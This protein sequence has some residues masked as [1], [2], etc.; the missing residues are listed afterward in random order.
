MFHVSCFMFRKT[1]SPALSRS[2]GRGSEQSCLDE[3]GAGPVGV[4]AAGAVAPVGGDEAQLPHAVDV[5]LQRLAGRVA[6]HQA[7]VED[8]LAVSP[9][10]ERDRSAVLR[11]VVD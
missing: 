2:T 3:F 11:G 1:L 4:V 10:L 8:L 5:Q 9:D 6:A 7:A